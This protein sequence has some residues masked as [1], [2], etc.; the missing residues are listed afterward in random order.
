[1]KSWGDISEIVVIMKKYKIDDE[2]VNDD[3]NDNKFASR[4]TYKNVLH[5][6]S[7]G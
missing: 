6:Y 1:M 3:D 5:S 2:D 7:L 4:Q